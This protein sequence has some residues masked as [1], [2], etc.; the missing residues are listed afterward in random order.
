MN[1]VV[2]ITGS[3]KGIG[4]SIAFELAQAGYAIVINY[5]FKRFKKK[6]TVAVYCS[7]IPSML[8]GR[9][10]WGAMMYM[11]TGIGFEAFLASAFINALP[12]IVLQL[13]LIPLIMN[14]VVK[15]IKDNYL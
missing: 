3:A 13:V 7:L 2:L 4:K 1:Q 15:N 11:L 10:A 14:F 6:N 12:G 5:I 8:L 9:F